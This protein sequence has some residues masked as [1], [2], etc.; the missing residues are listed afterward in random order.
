MSGSVVPATIV[1]MQSQ[2]DVNS[3]ANAGRL[4]FPRYQPLVIVLAAASAGIVADVYWP[5][6]IATWCTAALITLGLWYL[7]S[8]LGRYRAAV[9]SIFISILSVAGA[10]HHC[11]WN[12]FDE[13][14]LGNYAGV[15][16][17]P[18]ALEA[19]A[20]GAARPL[21]PP[22]RS[23]I[24]FSSTETSYRLDISAAAIRDAN[25]WKPISG[26]AILLVQGDMPP[27][28][29]GDRIRVLGEFSAPQPAHNPGEFDRAAYLRSHQ[30]RAQIQSQAECISIVEPGSPWNLSRWLERVRK[31][32]S[33]QF[34]K[35][36]DPRQAELASAVFL[37]ERE[38][39][40][41]ERNEAFM[42]TGTIHILSISGLHVGILAG[43]LLWIMR[44]ALVPRTLGLA[45]VAL[46][47]GLYA[48]MVDVNPP[49]VRATILVLVTCLSLYLGRPALSFN[50][51]AAAALVVLA[52]NPNDLFSVGAQLS[53]LS[54]ATI[55]WV[56]PHCLPIVP[57]M[58]KQDPLQ[59]MVLK[60]M[61]V[62]SRR[63]WQSAQ[64][65]WD[66]IWVGAMI[67]VITQPLVMAR[68]HIFSPIALVLN[69]VLWLPM[70]LGL[71]SG[72]VFLFLAALLPP[73]AG[74]AAYCC[75]FNL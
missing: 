66:L 30:I 51:L 36:L 25:Q 62:F 67:W 17:Q 63:F 70:T 72:F 40:D 14:D 46:I 48:L 19:V 41:Y 26:R 60:H 65:L 29:A 13:N 61:N 10:W 55:M 74:V 23:P 75:N 33:D 15:K 11:Q 69:A 50:T 28:E 59:K 45:L 71:L 56:W 31:S 73:L 68:F 32:G 7:L 20:L 57:I 38:Q 4:D 6:G 47:T 49:V 44:R 37:G 3:D 12:L 1:P 58:D 64:Y 42:A 8:K 52:I 22:E 18:I 35:H 24:R 54:V 34:E 43:A 39:I 16:K 21:P 9:A 27:I 5:K 2:T 53:F